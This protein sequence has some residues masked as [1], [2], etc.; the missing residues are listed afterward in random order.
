MS[1][2]VPFCVMAVIELNPGKLEK[3]VALIQEF[4]AYVQ[5]HEPFVWTYELTVGRSDPK[6]EPDIAI[7]K[8]VYENKAAFD[9]HMVSE[10]LKEILEMDAAENCAKK[11]KF[12]LM[13]FGKAAGFSSRS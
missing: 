9:K 12:Y 7:L 5:E 2:A 4:T 13:D 11:R 8:E 1:D 3:F 10:K 6:G